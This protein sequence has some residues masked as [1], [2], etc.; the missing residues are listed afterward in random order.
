[1]FVACRVLFCN[2]VR[3]SV[4][5]STHS[6]HCVFHTCLSVCMCVIFLFYYFGGEDGGVTSGVIFFVGG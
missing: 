3:L 2:T 1:M 6:Y 5:P 4:S